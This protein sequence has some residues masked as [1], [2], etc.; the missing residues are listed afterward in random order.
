MDYAIIG[1]RTGRDS[2]YV[3]IENKGDVAAPFPLVGENDWKG[4]FDTVWVDGFTGIK[5]IGIPRADYDLF[6]IDPGH[7]TLEAFRNNNEYR[8]KKTFPRFEPLQIRLLSA[9]ENE[10][11]S[12]LFLFPLLGYNSTDGFLIGMGVHNRAILPRTFE[13]GVAPLLGTQSESLAG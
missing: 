9:L 5:E 11:R 10:S 2:I 1:T 6:A 8:P 3:N 4:I 7:L 13:W 12:Q